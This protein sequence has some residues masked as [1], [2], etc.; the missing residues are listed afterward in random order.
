VSQGVNSKPSEIEGIDPGIG[1]GQIVDSSVL[2]VKEFTLLEGRVR[3]ASGI[4][5]NLGRNS[6]KSVSQVDCQDV[7]FGLMFKQG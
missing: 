3:R 2:G 6:G 5:E 4:D 7:L 1:K